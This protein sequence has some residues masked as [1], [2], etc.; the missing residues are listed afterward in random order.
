MEGR[1]VFTKRLPQT[2]YHA[3]SGVLGSKLSPCQSFGCP[4]APQDE[5][6]CDGLNSAGVFNLRYLQGYRLRGGLG[7]DP[8]LAEDIYDKGMHAEPTLAVKLL[9]SPGAK[10]G[11]EHRVGNF[12][13]G[14][15]VIDFHEPFGF[16]F[17]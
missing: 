4:T 8:L 5:A 15:P 13:Y 6:G 2:L 16:L 1:V 7:Q 9:H 17:I 3:L 10:K 11:E 14:I 12:G